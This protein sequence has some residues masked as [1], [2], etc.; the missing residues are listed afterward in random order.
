MTVARP[1]DVTLA[2]RRTPVDPPMTHD[3]LGR[4]LV[5][6]CLIWTGKLPPNRYARIKL[7]PVFGKTPQ[8][9]HRVAYALAHGIPMEDLKSLPHLD[10]LCRTPPCSAASHLEPVS[11]AENVRR[12]NG[13]QNV[14]KTECL[15]GHPYDAVNTFWQ[16]NGGR[17]CR[18]CKKDQTR[19]SWR[20]KHRPDLVGSP[21]MTYGDAARVGLARRWHPTDSPRPSR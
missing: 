3:R 16:K 20:R 5:G 17:S 8:L 18:T 14:G 6:P 19:E 13:N 11:C 4:P 10:H 21:P 7:E 9:V 1:L 15:R 12:G 2:L